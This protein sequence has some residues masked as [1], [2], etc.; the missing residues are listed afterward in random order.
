MAFKHRKSFDW[1]Y[2]TLQ[3]RSS[4]RVYLLAQTGLGLSCQRFI[5]PVKMLR[6]SCCLISHQIWIIWTQ[7]VPKLNQL[8][9]SVFRPVAPNLFHLPLFGVDMIFLTFYHA[10]PLPV[11][12]AVLNMAK[13]SNKIFVCTS[14]PCEPESQ[15]LDRFF[16][17]HRF[18]EVEQTGY[19]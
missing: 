19:S 5:A 17:L 7:I 11:T 15:P 2:Y 12:D 13:V 8:N 14:N 1:F 18:C 4:L 16:P 6:K 3:I 9:F 10:Y